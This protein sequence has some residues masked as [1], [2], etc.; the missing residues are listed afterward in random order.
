MLNMMAWSVS[1]AS[2][3]D[4]IE[5]EQAVSA[6]GLAVDAGGAAGDHESSGAGSHCNEGCHAVNH[7][8]GM[9]C[10]D[11]SFPLDSHFVEVPAPLP[12]IADASADGL[13]R[14]PRTSHPA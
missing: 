2:L 14:P 10:V 13:F 6:S 7:L 1:A 5:T 8:Q 11:L 3:L 9:A 12:F 4:W